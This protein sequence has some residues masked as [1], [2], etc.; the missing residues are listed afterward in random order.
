[1]Q[2]CG[3]EWDLVRQRPSI[4]E[5]WLSPARE[6]QRQSPPGARPRLLPP[7]YWEAEHPQLAVPGAEDVRAEAAT[8]AVEDRLDAAPLLDR[9]ADQ[10]VDKAHTP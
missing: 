3:C 4:S 2:C 8:V 9:L 7:A 1:M 5:T 10:L 6:R